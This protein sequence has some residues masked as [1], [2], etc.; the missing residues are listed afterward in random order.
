MNTNIINTKNLSNEQGEFVIRGIPSSPGIIMGKAQIIKQQSIYVHTKRIHPGNIQNEIERFKKAHDLLVNDYSGVI[1]KAGNESKNIIALLESNLMMLKD[2]FVVQEILSLIKNGSNSE[3]AVVEVFETIKQNML[4]SKD[5][6][7][8]DRTHEI[9]QM[10]HKLILTLRNQT[11]IIK[12]RE[13]AVIIAD[14]ITSDE[15]IRLKEMG[16][17]AIITEVGGI[18]SHSAILARNFGIVNVIGVKN[19]TEIINDNDTLIIDGYSGIIIVHPSESSIAKYEEKRKTEDNYKKQLGIL[20]DLP[21]KTADDKEIKLKVNINLAED[22]EIMQMVGADGV[23]LVRTEYLVISN[24][25]F[26]NCEEQYNWYKKIADQVY[27]EPVTFRVFDIGSDKIAE[28]L[29]HHENN[30]ALGF[31]GIRFLLQRKDIFVQQICAILRAARNKNVQILLPMITTLTELKRAKDI[32]EECKLELKTKNIPFDTDLPVGVM[33]ETP[34]AALIAC[35]LAEHC[36]FFSIGTNDLT[37]Y[38]IAADRSNELV[39]SHY[40]AFHPAVFRLIKMTIDAAKQAQI[41]VGVCGELAG[42]MAAT[43]ILIGLGIDELSVAPSILLEIK[44]RIRELNYSDAQKKAD[45][46]LM[47]KCLE[48]I[49]KKISL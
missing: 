22:I 47:C 15:I 48:E 16:V 26:P 40:D 36:D 33:V 46:L 14:F 11:D 45:E 13:G 42:H 6:F 17:A 27:P 39:S 4:N 12:A 30:P 25:K 29:P 43:D 8:R 44:K 34:A 23:G 2:D 18:T 37:Q 19:A 10:K 7:L 24:G 31:R 5:S 21:A 49:K 32:I 3:T 28:G 1:Q 38:T 9:D 35:E 20:K 41:P